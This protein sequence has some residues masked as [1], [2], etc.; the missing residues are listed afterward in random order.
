MSGKLLVDRGGGFIADTAT[1]E[2]NTN[3]GKVRRAYV[4]TSQNIATKR[5]REKERKGV[6]AQ[7]T[8]NN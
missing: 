1:V 3:N 8:T 6:A 4:Q 2:H 5:I 7:N